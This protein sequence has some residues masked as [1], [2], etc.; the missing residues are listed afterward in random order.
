[1]HFIA[2]DT[3][4]QLAHDRRDRFWPSLPPPPAAPAAA[5]GSPPRSRRAGS[6]RVSCEAR[7]P[8]SRQRDRSTA[9][10]SASTRPT[11]SPCGAGHRHRQ[12]GRQVAAAR[13]SAPA[14][15]APRRAHRPPST[16]RAGR[17]GR[18]GPA[19]A[20]AGAPAGQHRRLDRD[21]VGQ[22]EQRGEGVLAE[23]AGVRPVVGAGARRAPPRRAR[24]SGRA[25]LSR[26]S[27]GATNTVAT[28]GSYREPWIV[29]RTSPGSISMST[30]APSRA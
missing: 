13:G 19:S 21:L 16:S 17:R 2:V 22:R 26:S 23:G 1:M 30:T 29:A 25:R 3:A 20:V 27:L 10:A 7:R 18:A 8:R 28:Y 6:R 24:G 9:R 4:W 15:P 12:P 14:R 5:R 11:S